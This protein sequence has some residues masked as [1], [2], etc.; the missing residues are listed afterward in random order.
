[1][2]SRTPQFLLS[3]PLLLGVSFSILAQDAPPVELKLIGNTTTPYSGV[4][5]DANE[6]QVEIRLVRGGRLTLETDQ[7]DP[8]SLQHVYQY[9]LKNW[10]LENP[11]QRIRLGDFCKSINLFSFA[12]THYRAVLSLKSDSDPTEQIS[13]KLKIL[14][15]AHLQ[16]LLQTALD[17][18]SAGRQLEAVRYLR[19][20]SQKAP[21]SPEGQAAQKILAGIEVRPSEDEEKPAAPDPVSPSPSRWTRAIKQLVLPPVQKAHTLHRQGLNLEGKGQATRGAQCYKQA[22]DS[23]DLAEKRAKLVERHCHKKADLPDAEEQ[24]SY[25]N[26]QTDI[27]RLR[28]QL[29]LALANHHAAARR[30]ERAREFTNLALSVDPDEPSALTL[31]DRITDEILR[32]GVR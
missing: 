17:A 13:Q 11:A 14:E 19:R 29:Y 10:D 20:I 21:A 3:L 26:L 9:L 7:L 31:R 23:L 5:L 27:R 32:R 1:M 24:Q 4:I 16:H 28:I 12:E 18:L 30:L 6:K 2:L 8:T 15:Q 25:Q 22:V